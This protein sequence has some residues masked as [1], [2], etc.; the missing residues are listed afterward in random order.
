MVNTTK[1]TSEDIF[2]FLKEIEDPEIPV[3][4]IVELGIVRDVKLYDDKI[5]ISITPT[6]SGCPAM[7]VIEDQVLSSLQEKGL[8]NIK[9]KT[10]YSPAWTTDWITHETKEKLRKYGIT[11]P[12]KVS[13]E[14]V[15]PFL[16]QKKVD[17]QCPYCNST[18]TRVT[19]KFG[20]TP[21]KA[22]HFCNHCHQPF[23]E[24]KCI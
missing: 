17:V 15:F 23:E 13:V 6:Y 16:E 21:C 14:D 11:P 20:S 12:S 22:L 8:K 2:N 19:S 10:I 3:I 1:Y 9:I 7:K 5:E 24:F 18:E 4:N